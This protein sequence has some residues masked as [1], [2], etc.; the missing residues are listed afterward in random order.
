MLSDRR[1]DHPHPRV[2]ALVTASRSLADLLERDE[3]ALALVVADDPLPDRGGYLS[4]L[5]AA[6]RTEGFPG[7]RSAKHRLLAQVAGRDLAGEMSLEEVGA[8]LAALADACLLAGLEV[9]EA[10]PAL[11]VV[12]LGKLGG[13][14]LNYSSDIDVVFVSDGEPGACL[15][16]AERLLAELGG[17]APTGQAYRID[18]NL[19]PE[20]RAG[21]LVRSVASCLEYYGRWAETWEHQALIKARAVTDGGPAAELA[22]ETR[23]LVYPEE[24]TGERVAAV[25]AMKE[26]IEEH[27]ARRSR[28]GRPGEEN[29]VK[30]GPGGIRDIEFSVQLLQLVHGCSDPGVRSANTLEALG[31]LVDRGYVAEDDGAGLSVAY[32]WLRTVEHRLQLWQQRQVH[33]LPVAEEDRA[34]LARV[35]GYKDG[36]QESAAARF[37]RTHRGVL[38]DVRNRFEKLFYRPMIES[39]ADPVGPRLSPEALSDRLRVLGFRDVDRAF[40]TLDGLVSGTS[41]RAKLFRVLTPALLR[42]LAASPLPDDGLFSFLTL[43]EALESRLDVLGSLRDNP[44]GLALLARVLGHGRVLGEILSHVP[45]ELALFSDPAGPGPPKE[46]DRLLREARASLEWRA[47]EQRLD[48]LRRFKRREMLRTVLADLSAGIDVAGAG[49]ALADLADACLQAAV[50]EVPGPLAVIGMGKLGGRELNYSSDIDVMFVCGSDHSAG[51]E[52]AAE[53]MRAIGEVSPEGQA[54]RIDAGLRPEGRN[55]PL[56]R[57]VESYREYYERWSSPWERLALIKARHAAGDAGLAAAVLEI[58]GQRAFG[59]PA[60]GADLA[61]IRRLKAR[62]ERERI[63]RGTDPRRHLKL[64]PGGLSDIEFAA[65]M[66]Q[67]THGPEVP[68]LRAGSTIGALEAAVGAGLLEPEAA[69]RL[70]DGYR[71]LMGLRNR[72][73][74]QFGKPVDVLPTRPED[75]EALGKAAGF[76]EQPRQELEEAYLRHTRRVRRI[77]EPLIYD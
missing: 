57:T 27:A 11:G 61:E 77:A 25:R 54:F 42:F 51:A 67:L 22:E 69:R 35:L 1:L 9:V 45:E 70:Q 14:E 38:S 43:G 19:R 36:P 5:Q 58:A 3:H 75:L 34:R 26:R 10:P 47:P 50:D 66:L 24:V 48:G 21:P 46:R 65:Q 32:R 40:R 8:A 7:I 13:R 6:A 4:A 60:S 12:G 28:R 49:A 74:L 18:T 44:A 73:F 29:D 31:A 37:E 76:S 30:L 52:A 33:R 23:A 59:Q 71:F 68:G 56:V 62:M 72:L 15:P 64:G 20:G 55:G 16:A 63:P 41:R 53:L 39:L 2:R 17:F